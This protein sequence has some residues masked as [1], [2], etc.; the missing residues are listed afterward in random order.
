MAESRHSQAHK[1]FFH[2]PGVT[3]TRVTL[4]LLT[5]RK[6]DTSEQQVT[7][8]KLISKSDT[9]SQHRKDG[10][11]VSNLLNLTRINKAIYSF[12]MQKRLR[13]TLNQ[14]ST[15]LSIASRLAKRAKLSTVWLNLKEIPLPVLS[16]KLLWSKIPSPLERLAFKSFTYFYTM[17]IRLSNTSADFYC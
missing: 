14:K 10:L 2:R 3:L 8:W 16:D 1:T 9:V 7:T 5:P 4:K 15:F 6:C 13:E 11:R 17:N 12:S